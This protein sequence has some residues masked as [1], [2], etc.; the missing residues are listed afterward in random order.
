MYRPYSDGL[1]NSCNES[2][3]SSCIL[4]RRQWW[5]DSHN[6]NERVNSRI[7]S[8]FAAVVGVTIAVVAYTV[9]KVDGFSTSNP[10]HHRIQG[11][12][13]VKT[14]SK[15]LRLCIP[16]RYGD[17]SHLFGRRIPSF[18]KATSTQLFLSTRGN[19]SSDQSEWKA[20]LLALQLY[21]AAYGDLKVPMLF[22]VPSMAPW[23]GTSPQNEIISFVSLAYCWRVNRLS[24]SL[25]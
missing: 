11:S 4:I 18:S 16:S 6:L 23:P 12:V 20:V 5:D 21:K 13:D 7:L 3:A 25:L 1:Q 9:A 14:L 19:K 10:H 8:R 2:I 22:V 17:P 24:R 15:D